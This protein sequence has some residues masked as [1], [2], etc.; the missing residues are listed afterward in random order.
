[1]KSFSGFVVKY[2]K[3]ILIVGLLLL[4]PSMIGYKLT[5]TNYD[6]LVY[7]PSDIETLKGQNILKDDF[8]MGAFSVSLVDNNISD[9]DLI[10]LENKIRDIEC[11]NE[12]IS[13]NDITGTT[14]PLEILPKNLLNRIS[15][16]DS[17][18]LL[19]TFESGTSDEETSN[20]INEIKKLSNDIKVGGMS[21]MAM[22]TRKLVE[23]QTFVY[24]LIAVLCCLFILAVSL[25]S[26]IVPLLLL[27]NIGIS[28]LF[29]MGTNI[30]LGEISYI[31]KA[32]AAV[33][34][35]GVTTDFSIFL[36]HKYE[37]AKMKNK[38]NDEAMVEAINE[39]MTSVIGSS[40]TTIAGFLALCSMKFSLGEDI[41]LVMAKGVVFG[42]LTVLT[43]Y[44]SIILL[45]D[46]VI[47]KTK[48]KPLI[49]KFKF[50]KPIVVKGYKY[51]FVIFLLLLVP[52]YLS[53]RKTEVYYN[54]DKSIPKDYDY[55]IVSKKLEDEYGLITQSIILVDSNME[56]ND[57]N[58][59][60]DEINNLDGVDNIISSN[61][62]SKYGI[63]SSILPS[64]IKKLLETDKYKLILVNSSYKLATDEL[65]NQISEINKI[66]KKYDNNAI[67]AGEGPLMNDLVEITAIDLRNV[68]YVSIGVIFLI[69][70]FVLK[71]FSLPILLVVSIEFAIFINMGIPYWQDNSIPFVS[72][73]V[74]GTIQLGATIDYA[75]LLTT[76]YLEERKNGK[77]KISS[78]E[79]ALDSSVSSI[80][81][82]AMCFFGAT[83][84]V[85]AISK[86]DMIGSLCLLMARG[87][88]I[89][90]A[91]VMFIV[92]SVLLVFDKLIVKTTLGFKKGKGKMRKSVK[93][94][95]VCIL[96]SSLI[97]TT[98]VYATTKEESVYAKLESDGSVNNIVVSE[99]L[100]DITKNKVND[101]TKLFDLKN[102]NSN[103]SFNKEGDNLVWKT[104]GSDIYY[105]GTYK[106]D[107]PIDVSVKYYLDGK[108]KNIDEILGKKGKVRIVL[109]YKNNYSKKMNINGTKKDIYV[110]YMIVTTSIL[111]NADNKNIKV[112]NG[113][114]VDN[115]VSSIVIALSSP[116]LYESL[117]IDDLKD[118]NKVEISYETDKFELNPIYSV[119]T[120]DIIE[121]KELGIFNEVNSLYKKIDELQNNMD[122][123]VSASKK[124]SNGTTAIDNG[125]TEL[126][127]NLKELV[128]KYEYYRNQDQNTLKEQLIKIVEENI[129]NITPLLEEE[130]S[131]ETSKV[132]KSHKDELQK[133]MIDSLKK[134]T[135]AIVEE[136]LEKIV[137]SLDIN[138]IINDIVKKDIA[139]I[140]KND[141]EIDN[142]TKL[143]KDD[144]DKKLK[145]II[146]EEFSKINSNVSNNISEEYINELAKKYGV[147]YE[148]A[149]GIANDVKNDT[150]NQVKENINN[151]NIPDKIINSLNEKNYLND[152]IKEYVQKLSNKIKEYLNNDELIN[153]YEEKIK[154]E[155]V[156][157]IEEKMSNDDAYINSDIKKYVDSVVDK[158]IDKTV[159]DLADKYTDDYTKEVVRNVIEK[160][161]SEENVDSKL[162]QILN[163][164]EDDVKEK[165]NILDDT[166]STLTTSMDKLNNGSNLVAKG[167]K[168]LSN[169]LEKY[170]KLGINKIS[171]TVNGPVKSTQKRLESIVKLSNEYKI[172]D[173][174]DSKTDGKSKIIFMIDSDTSSVE[175]ST[176]V[177]EVKNNKTNKT[178]K[179]FWDKVKNLFSAN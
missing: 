86:I 39:T 110:P 118:I 59:M 175:N 41:G 25:D 34:Q 36:Y 61:L 88:I 87:A 19:I 91:V 51:I 83:F 106:G 93:R 148:Q 156:K 38:S 108:E 46:K 20:A 1:M 64:R 157:T 75:I 113:R 56:T 172:L 162:R 82:S 29:N 18:L 74:I 116:G 105:Q 65:N 2:K 115:G 16:D 27:G 11:V 76:K 3:I 173:D 155:I 92:P 48:H 69:M 168:E 22:D 107:L 78:I 57:M 137:N 145:N 53:Q 31:T 13:I 12:V 140:L 10:N 135:Q 112:T 136:E 154:E 32:I 117:N 152:L 146:N 171:S 26:Y 52:A 8:N 99:H 119:A 15:S 174:K 129:N 60:I 17:K 178:K 85:F 163:K 33:L 179:S 165:V 14:I 50:I 67:L 167:T 141:T 55:S 40:L 111:N 138:K 100:Y 120:I 125:V 139:N 97:F 147:T 169:G 131:T 161:F 6:I 35:L 47:K 58:N 127:N 79:E 133:S 68:N 70:F 98:K 170:N 62:L 150:L 45:F 159:S 177:K 28:I 63:S 54:L 143:L 102:L 24:V 77:D 43:I 9:N 90:M 95:L 80:F 44:P 158:I 37:A 101:K 94:A 142:L 151:S 23:S 7:L 176:S 96:I 123:I 72:S 121:D 128:K 84:G 164:Y 126:N 124:L 144:I 89:S 160:Q 5:K 166:I 49:P 66:I 149:L 81:V 71:S 73:I 103:N 4:I 30:F 42:V 153:E 104:D 109:K 122:K 114:I 21:V 130:I 132:L 134:N